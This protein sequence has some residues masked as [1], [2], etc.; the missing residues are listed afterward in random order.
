MTTLSSV[1]YRNSSKGSTTE[2]YQTK[3]SYQ[4]GRVVWATS[5][6]QVR[7]RVLE[8]ESRGVHVLKVA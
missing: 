5:T 8:L 1:T 7:L 4:K 6:E 3:R 2:T